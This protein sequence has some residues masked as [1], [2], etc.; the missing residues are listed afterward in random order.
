MHGIALARHPLRRAHFAAQPRICRR[1]GFR[2]ALGIGANTAIFSILDALLLRE[3]PVSQPRQL[4][5]LSPIYR[6]GAR[7]PF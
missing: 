6:N 7:V 1:H 5:E 3:L 4:V 2:F